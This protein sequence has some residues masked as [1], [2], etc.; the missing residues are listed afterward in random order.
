MF[1]MIGGIFLFMI[2][3][4]HTLATN[5]NKL[6]FKIFLSEKLYKLGDNTVNFLKIWLY[7]LFYPIK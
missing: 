7:I 6:N 4:F 3:V 5:Y 2:G 1:G